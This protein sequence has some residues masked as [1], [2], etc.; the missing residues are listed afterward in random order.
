MNEEIFKISKNEIR[1]NSLIEMAKER[2]DD[3]KKDSK[4]YKII[5]EYY[6]ITKELITALMYKEGY[7]TLS[8]KALVMYLEEKYKE[9]DR[10]EIV[11]IDGLRKLRNNILYYGQKVEK[12]YLVNNEKDIVNIIKKLF[13]VVRKD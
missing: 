2:F 8:H 12:E 4:P 9:F 6:E 1:A 10:S 7:K 13:G 3:I 5:E 11:L